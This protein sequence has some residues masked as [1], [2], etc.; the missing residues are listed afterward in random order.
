MDNV[1]EFT[2]VCYYHGSSPTQSYN[3]EKAVDDRI[4]KYITY[5]GEENKLFVEKQSTGVA[6][7]EKRIKGI[8]DG[9]AAEECGCQLMF[10]I[11]G[12]DLK[13]HDFYKCYSCKNIVINAYYPLEN[14]IIP[15]RS[16]RF[17][18]STLCD[19]YYCLDKDT[20]RDVYEM[21][22]THNLRKKF[23]TFLI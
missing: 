19:G 12:D 20:D 4:S 15:G 3:L 10:K 1:R 14:I 16:C 2:I 11:L 5:I 7:W 21:D 18:R 23:I 22:S 17:C 8:I 13:R 9:N 6:G